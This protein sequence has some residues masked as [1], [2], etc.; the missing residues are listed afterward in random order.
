MNYKFFKGCIDPDIKQPKKAAELLKK[1]QFAHNNQSCL[2]VFEIPFKN[3]DQIL[4]Q[5]LATINEIEQ[6]LKKKYTN[7]TLTK[8]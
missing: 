2:I 5:E 3:V 6:H 7:A 8:D 1:A 4:K